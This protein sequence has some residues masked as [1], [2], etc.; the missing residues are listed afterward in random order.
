MLAFS[1]FVTGLAAVAV[2]PDLAIAALGPAQLWWAK[3]FVSVH[4][5]ASLL[6]AV[7]GVL[8]VIRWRAKSTLSAAV[9]I[10]SL[11]VLSTVVGILIQFVERLGSAQAW[12]WIFIRSG[13]VPELLYLAVALFVAATA[14][15]R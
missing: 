7:V 3:F 8:L 15:E 10:S 9:A 6:A 4:W 11:L 12:F 1:L 13:L 2:K 5:G 14:D